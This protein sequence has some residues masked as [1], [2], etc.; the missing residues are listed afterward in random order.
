M[1]TAVQQPTAELVLITPCESG[2]NFDGWS[3]IK[4]KIAQ[5]AY[6]IFE[7]RGKTHG[8]DVD[9]WLRAERVI[10]RP[11]P[12]HVDEGEHLYTVTADVDGFT[13][14][15]LSVRAEPFRI[16][17]EGKK[18]PGSAQLSV[19]EGQEIFRAIELGNEIEANTVIAE[20]IDGDLTISMRKAFTNPVSRPSKENSRTS[21]KHSAQLRERAD[22]AKRY[23]AAAKEQLQRATAKGRKA[24]ARVISSRGV[25]ER[26]EHQYQVR[27]NLANL[28]ETDETR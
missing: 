21:R 16:V 28:A 11:V 14:T 15:E 19:D 17:I 2:V 27:A 13:A 9:D 18:T 5:R 23:S 20:L 6:Q 22:I 10:L 12:V 8:Y 7:S 25:A 3:N 24:Q 1:A 4:N 26:S